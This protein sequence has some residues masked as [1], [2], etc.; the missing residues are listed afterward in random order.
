MRRRTVIPNHTISR[1][2]Q[3]LEAER[4]DCGSTLHPISEDR[5]DMLDYVPAQLRV[6]LIR[7]PRYGCRA[8]EQ[9]VVQAQAPAWP[10]D[11]GIA[12]EALIAHVLVNKF[13]DHLPLYRQSASSRVRADAGSFHALHLGGSRLLVA[14]AA[15]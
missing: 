11:G 4:P 7:R 6:K 15:A 9:A 3:L 14:G 5:A 13:A 2:W 1:F 8:C 12:T 10:I